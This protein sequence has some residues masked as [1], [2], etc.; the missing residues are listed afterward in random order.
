[1]LNISCI[2]AYSTILVILVILVKCCHH[3]EIISHAMQFILNC[4]SVFNRNVHSQCSI[5]M[6]NHIVTLSVSK[7][8]FA[9][10]TQ[11][12]TNWVTNL[13]WRV[14]KLQSINS[15]ETRLQYLWFGLPSAW[16]KTS[17]CR[18]IKQQHRCTPGVRGV[19]PCSHPCTSIHTPLHWRRER[20]LEDKVK[21]TW[22]HTFVSEG[23]EGRNSFQIYKVMIRPDRDW[24]RT[25]E[26]SW[27]DRGRW[28][29]VLECSWKMT[30]LCTV[31]LGQSNLYAKVSSLLY[32]VVGD[33]WCMSVA[34]FDM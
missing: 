34:D 7:S 23:P 5:T 24:K 29:S 32:S 19:C 28:W 22:R 9:L 15:A 33:D 25:L 12:D 4:R 27:S 3:C 2:F 16:R 11:I 10:R 31:R 18:V 13:C 8:R 26:G 14:V 1:M 30:S 20:D 17:R 21:A 6:F